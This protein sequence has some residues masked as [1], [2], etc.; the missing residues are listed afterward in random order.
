MGQFLDIHLYITSVLPAGDFKAVTLHLALDLMHK[1]TTRDLITGL[2]T[3]TSAGRPEWDALFEKFGAAGHGKV[4][5]FY[6][7]NPTLA[8]AL[9]EKCNRH[10]FAF[11][12]EIF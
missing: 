1:K 11:K 3:R 7:G 10:K 6:C 8:D 2:K 12:K 4:T 9:H 5:V